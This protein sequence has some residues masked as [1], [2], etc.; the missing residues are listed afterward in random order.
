MCAKYELSTINHHLS[1]SGS[2][3]ERVMGMKRYMYVEGN[4]V[5]SR[6]PLGHRKIGAQE[7]V[8]LV[9]SIYECAQNAKSL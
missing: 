5:N 2:F 6:D 8:L 7:G 3:P 9:Y 1:T 4:P